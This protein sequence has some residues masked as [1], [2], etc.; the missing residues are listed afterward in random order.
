MPEVSVPVT[1][2]TAP[3]TAVE[4]AAVPATETKPTATKAAPAKKAPVKK[5]PAAKA[6]AP[7]KKAVKAATRALS[8]A[9]GTD[10][11]EGIRAKGEKAPKAVKPA[12]VKKAP[13][14]P[15]VIENRLVPEGSK[16]LLRLLNSL[17]K[18]K[19][20]LTGKTLA[21]NSNLDP[22]M[23]GLYA[24]YR[25]PEINARPCHCGN[26]IN[27]KYAKVDKHDVDGKD[28]WAYTITAAGR[29]Y[30]EKCRKAEKAAKNA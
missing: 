10:K 24:G 30:L 16:T 5:A 22:S 28:V 21:T 7:T 1:V 2:E 15:K 27:L 11:G 20:P 6:A 9:K 23:I 8:D 29:N 12:A 17:D 25:N 19:G 4:T 3:A 18:A 14:T 26:L 13:K